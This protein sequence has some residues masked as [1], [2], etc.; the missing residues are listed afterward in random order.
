MH[1]DRSDGDLAREGVRVY[2]SEPALRHPFLLAREVARDA[3]SSRGLAWQL[4]VRDLKADYR[5]SLLGY[6]WALL[7][8]VAW[9]AMFVVLHDQGIVRSGYAGSNYAAFVVIGMVLWQVFVDALQAPIRSFGQARSLLGKI[10]FP[11][12]ALILAGLGNVAFQFILRMPLLAWAWWASGAP[13]SVHLLCFAVGPI[14]LLLVGTAL[15]VTL[16]PISLLYQDARSA[17]PLITSFWLLVTPVAYRQPGGGWGA[18]LTQWN[19][20]SPLVVN[21]RAWLLG[22]TADAVS[23]F[24]L[25]TGAAVLLLG[26]SWIVFRVALPHAVAR[27]GS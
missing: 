22:S 13:V 15:G 12:E 2:S 17:L 6:V 16:L 9:G 3:A 1:R 10:N 7:P 26:V 5:Q 24:F 11:R 23:G 14:A 21:S 19:P 27:L 8:P 18:T 20:I 4:F 25:I